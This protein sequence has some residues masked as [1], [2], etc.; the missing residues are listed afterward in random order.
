MKHAHVVANE[1]LEHHLSFGGAFADGLKRHGWRVTAG[2]QPAVCDMLVM[3]GV[4]RQDLIEDQKRA[5]GEVCILERGYIG[6]RFDY[7]SVS[8][9]GGLNGR[10]I[11]RGPHADASRWERLFAHL[12]KPWRDDYAGYVLV[13]G[14]VPGDNSIRGVNIDAFYANA[15][16]SYTARGWE[17]R[18][19]PHPHVT[20]RDPSDRIEAARL[21]LQADLA[22]A[23]VVVTWN[24][25]TA[26]DAVLAGVPTV[27]MDRGSMAWDVTGHE[28]GVIP[29]ATDRTSWAHRLA[30]CQ[31]LIEEIRS[32][33]C[34][35]AIGENA[36][37]PVA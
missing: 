22:G 17:A 13:M 32:G 19:R 4:R 3:W 7:T 31:W 29:E 1:R 20:P 18:F 15:R 14:Q 36:C 28:L 26:V 27:A 6:D 9:G 33:D 23:A 16:Q 11:Y 10:G 30:W 25:N 24:S 5:G 12:I 8:F 37:E 2:G 21:S 34:W 35:A